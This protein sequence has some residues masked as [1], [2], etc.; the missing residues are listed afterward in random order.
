MRIHLNLSVRGALKWSN[1]EMRRN[2]PSMMRDDGTHYRTPDEFRDALMDELANGVECLA[3]GDCD[4][5]D[6]KKGCL[7]HH[8][9]TEPT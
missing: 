5:F 6:P 8:D 3:I 4:N 9:E 1:T 2:L 7:G